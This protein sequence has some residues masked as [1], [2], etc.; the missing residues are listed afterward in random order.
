MPRGLGHKL[1]KSHDAL[2]CGT[3]QN[4]PGYKG[5]RLLPRGIRHAEDTY[6]STLGYRRHQVCTQAR[7]QGKRGGKSEKL[8]ARREV[9]K[10]SMKKS[11]NNFCTFDLLDS[12]VY[13]EGTT[14]ALL[15][16][17]GKNEE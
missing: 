8:F 13:N 5:V 10:Q 2:R 15:G 7:D 16:K 14:I 17:R 12:V 4:L 9:I 1:H 11:K 3:L 6:G